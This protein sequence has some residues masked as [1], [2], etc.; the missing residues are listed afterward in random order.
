V[1]SQSAALVDVIELREEAD[2]ARYLASLFKDSD[3]VSDLL[4]YA[5]ALED[6]ADRWEEEGTG[7]G[8]VLM[9]DKLAGSM[10][11]KIFL[12]GSR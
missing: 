1:P 7:S 12:A 5:A 10:W 11:P 9:A 3:T 8:D 6:D 4:S 2:E